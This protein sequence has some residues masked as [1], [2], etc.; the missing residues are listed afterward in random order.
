VAERR[1]NQLS[2]QGKYTYY[3]MTLKSFSDSLKRICVTSWAQLARFQ[4]VF[5][6]PRKVITELCD[7]K[8]AFVK[9]SVY[10]DLYA[11]PN[12]GSPL[13]II[14][15]SNF[16]SGPVGLMQTL[17]ADYYIVNVE[18]DTECRIW[19]EK[20]KDF[21]A[22][23]FWI[24]I[25]EEQ[26]QVAVQAADIDWSQY[27]L[28]L[29]LEN[30][31]P[32]RITQ[33]H[34]TVLWA[35]MVE[36]HR[37]SIYKSYLRTPPEGYDCFFNQRFGPTLRSL[38]RSAHVI[39]WPYSFSNEKCVADLFPGTVKENSIVVEAHQPREALQTLLKAPEIRVHF[40][41]GRNIIEHLELLA[42]AK[43]LFSPIYERPLWGNATVE[44]AAADCIV[45]G[46]RH[47][48][49]NP[50]MIDPR[51]HCSSVEKGWEIISWL[52]SDD[53]YYQEML[54]SQRTRLNWYAF[55]RPLLQL[56]YYVSK[57]PRPLSAKRFVR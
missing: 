14:A 20:R 11:N 38:H 4:E 2:H 43:I 39:E 41:G 19:E 9:Q 6:S 21:K 44:A 48:L 22:R 16:R 26:K 12:A 54:A 42:K 23:P 3:G 56:L 10:T 13:E 33:Q 31:I 55:S 8:V 15:S 46:N 27:D 45:V 51:M 57:S 18:P 5:E 17:R 24:H 32:A 29:A 35:T 28:V 34:P 53:S 52:L 40:S 49:W 50:C 30:A 37:M 47:A 7:L 36:H 1:N 25:I